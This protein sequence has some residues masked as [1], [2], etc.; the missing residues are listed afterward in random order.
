MTWTAEKI[1]PPIAGGGVFF[2]VI[3]TNR[4]EI[5]EGTTQGVSMLEVLTLSI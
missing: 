5:I 4:N 1:T 3:H 2:T